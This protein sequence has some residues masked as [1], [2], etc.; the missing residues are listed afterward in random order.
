MNA[1]VGHLTGLSLLKLLGSFLTERQRRNLR[2]IILDAATQLKEVLGNT[3]G[4]L[5]RIPVVCATR[6]EV[7]TRWTLR[8]ETHE[9]PAL[10]HLA[11]HAEERS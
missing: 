2:N 4:P 8:Q 10:T 6:A 11:G 3:R 5:G 1:T 7:K 9:R